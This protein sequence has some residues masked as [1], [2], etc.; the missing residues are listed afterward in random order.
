MS[1]GAFILAG[2]FT[3]N[4]KAQEDNF[5]LKKELPKELKE[6][7][8]LAKD[9]N[10]LWAIVDTKNADIYKLD[11]DG[12]ILQ[13]IHLSNYKLKDVEAVSID[14][15]YLYVGDVGDNN[16]TRENRT[17]IRIAKSS[18]GNNPTAT[19]TG[20]LINFTF[21]D[22]GIVKKK[23]NNNYDC[24][25]MISYKDSLFV[26]T[27]RRDDLKTQLYVLPKSPGT[28]SA[29]S[30]ALFK[31]KGLVTDAAVN[32]KG[33]EIALIGYDEGHTR[34]FIWILSNFSGN[35]FFS[36]NYKR[37]EL[38]NERKLDWQL[39]SIEYKNYD[40]FFIAC[41]KSKDVSNTLYV[42]QKSELLKSRKGKS[43]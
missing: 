14:R 41:E 17:I 34:P 15:K 23:K 38:T 20:D 24:E 40:S 30:I 6:I 8:G 26:F 25:A 4:A 3:I 39:E 28:Y 18:I 2:I 42:L 16:G 32:E 7:S 29:R 33:N 37:F 22:E 27:K 35:N 36:G 31:T 13:I 5:E 43:K 9:G 10:V 1:V 21:P 12:N 11:L 19:V